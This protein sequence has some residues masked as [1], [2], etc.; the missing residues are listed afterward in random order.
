MSIKL[1]PD[2]LGCQTAYKWHRQTLLQMHIHWENTEMNQKQN[3]YLFNPNILIVIY[4]TVCCSFL[5]QLW[6]LSVDPFNDPRVTWFSTGKAQILDYPAIFVYLPKNFQPY[7]GRH[8]L[9]GS[10]NL[11][12]CVT[13][14]DKNKPFMV[15][16]S[17]QASISCYVKTFGKVLNFVTGM[18]NGPNPWA[19]VKVPMS[20]CKHLSLFLSPVYLLLGRH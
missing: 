2:Q 4:L 12:N 20:F 17:K 14:K 7:L 15:L 3:I 9:T 11:K 10:D 13:S 19:Q 16:W 6:E 18:T 5:L 8:W 1:L